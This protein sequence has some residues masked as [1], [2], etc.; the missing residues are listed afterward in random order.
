[1]MLW[2]IPGSMILC[3]VF[4]ALRPWSTFWQRVQGD[5]C[6]EKPIFGNNL[7]MFSQSSAICDLR[8]SLAFPG[9]N[10][11]AW[12]VGFTWKLLCHIWFF[13]LSEWAGE[14]WLSLGILVLDLFKYYVEVE[15]QK[16]KY[17]VKELN[18]DRIII[19]VTS[20]RLWI[21]ELPCLPFPLWCLPGH[22]LG[23]WVFSCWHRAGVAQR[24]KCAN[25][26]LACSSYELS[27][28][29]TMKKW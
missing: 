23:K 13:Q 15:E 28:A 9:R 26:M 14:S 22:L 6:S 21:A 3:W 19:I 17:W 16:P 20:W 24:P 29:Y 25:S 27:D 4:Q 11:P 18:H 1:M 2:E 12:R 5:S 8:V 7:L 10:L